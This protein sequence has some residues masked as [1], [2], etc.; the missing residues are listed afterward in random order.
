MHAHSHALRL[1]LA[2]GK[3]TSAI[4]R[5]RNCQ[6]LS[7]LSYLICS[8]ATLLCFLEKYDACYVSHAVVGACNVTKVYMISDIRDCHLVEDTMHKRFIKAFL[9][10][11]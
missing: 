9:K 2:I 8:L 11:K 10:L 5:L 3:T 1:F 6:V 4:R 7:Y